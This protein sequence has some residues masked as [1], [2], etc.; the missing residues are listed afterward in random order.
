L[1][2]IPLGAW[3]AGVAFDL[4][5]VP[6]AADASF[7]VGALAAVPTAGAGTADWLEITDEPRR[8]DFVHAALNVAALVLVVL[9]LR[10][11]ASGSRGMGV[12]PIGGGQPAVRA[13]GLAGR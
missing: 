4:V 6:D 3:T 8:V 11:R 13:V 5:G 2:D 10:A 1:T 7:A 12:G 9:S